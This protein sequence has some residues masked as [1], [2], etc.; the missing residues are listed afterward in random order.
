M[1]YEDEDVTICAWCEEEIEIKSA[2]DESLWWCE[3]CQALEPD[4]ITMTRKEYE[5]RE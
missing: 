1:N 5:E 4:V 2:G 3:S